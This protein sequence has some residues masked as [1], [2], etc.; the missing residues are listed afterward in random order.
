MVLS[1]KSKSV[2]FFNP[3]YHCSFFLRDELRK[4]GWKAEISVGSWYPQKALWAD[5]VLRVRTS[6][7]VPEHLSRWIQTRRFRYIVHYGAMA[8]RGGQLERLQDW[9]ISNLATL[10]RRVGIKFIYLPSGCFEHRLRAKWQLVDGGNVC[11]N[12]GFEDRC[13][14]KANSKNF[15][16]VRRIAQSGIAIDAHVSEEFS[17]SRLRY[18]S[19]DLEIF[20]PDI[21]VP[22]EYRWPKSSSVRILHSSSLKGRESGGKNIKGS[23]YVTAA[24]NSL[25]AQGIDVELVSKTSE[26]SRIM[27]FHQVQADIIVDQLIYGGVGSTALEGMALGR[28]VICYIRDSWREALGQWFPEWRTC[29][30][31]SATPDTVESEIRRLVEDADLRTHIGKESRRFAEKFLDV[32]RNVLELEQLLYSL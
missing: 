11:G 2:L 23:P 1:R 9:V 15:E 18:K 27:R 3:D 32:K 8:S 30:I 5:D 19:F 22:N 20:S 4:R 26:P 29:P 7:F 16:L 28:P 13:N 31:I 14:D 6:R 17:E 24:I 10:L 12:C 21:E 25:R